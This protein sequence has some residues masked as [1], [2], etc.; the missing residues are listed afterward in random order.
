MAKLDRNEVMKLK[1]VASEEI[2][3][4][5]AG[6]TSFAYLAKIQADSWLVNQL[7]GLLNKLLKALWVEDLQEG[8]VI[9]INLGIITVDALYKGDLVH[10]DLLGLPIRIRLAKGEQLATIYIG[11]SKIELNCSDD[12][13]IQNNAEDLKNEL[14]I[15]LIKAN[16]TRIANCKISGIPVGYDVYGGGRICRIQQRGASEGKLYGICRC[17]PGNKRYDRAVYGKERV[18]VRMGI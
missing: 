16:R 4:G 11:D 9:H 7:V 18:E 17:Y 10:V 6:K 2:A 1:Q 3:G 8:K 14:N 15:S 5:F 12:G 13:T